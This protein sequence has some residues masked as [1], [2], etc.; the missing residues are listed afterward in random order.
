MTSYDKSYEEYIQKNLDYERKYET[1]DF[2]IPQ[3]GKAYLNGQ[4]SDNS[5]N[6][7][8]SQNNDQQAQ[9]QATD[10]TVNTQNNDQ[11]QTQ[12]T[13]NNTTT[14]TNTQEQAKVLPETGES[15]N[16]T[17]LTIVASVLLA[18]GSLLVFRRTSKSNK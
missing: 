17:I 15:S 14:Q 11:Q 9:N 1:V 3:E 18:A 4:N 12:T 10:N 7:Q 8:L 2:K 13:D 5:N 6:Q 16:T